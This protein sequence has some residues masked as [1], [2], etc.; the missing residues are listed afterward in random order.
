MGET[1]GN[2]ILHENFT[3]NNPAG[4]REDSAKSA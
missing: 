2:A 3:A 1:V 4:V